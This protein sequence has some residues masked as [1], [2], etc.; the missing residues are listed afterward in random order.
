MNFT[1]AKKFPEDGPEVFLPFS[2]SQTHLP[3]THFSPIFF[4]LICPLL[5][6]FS[7]FSRKTDRIFSMDWYVVVLLGRPNSI[8]F[9]FFLTFSPSFMKIRPS[10]FKRM[11]LFLFYS[12]SFSLLSLTL[13]LTLSKSGRTK[14]NNGVWFGSCLHWKSGAPS[15]SNQEKY[16]FGILH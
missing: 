13:S 7:T 5:I 4:R 11:F 16:C 12:F 10:K 9:F 14:R 15:Y 2:I 6:E 1:N 3:L 8:F